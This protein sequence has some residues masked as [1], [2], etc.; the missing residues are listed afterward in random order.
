MADLILQVHFLHFQ[1]RQLILSKS[2]LPFLTPA[3][4]G[5]LFI[6]LSYFRLPYLLLSLFLSSDPVSCLSL[7]LLRLRVGTLSLEIPRT[8]AWASTGISRDWRFVAAASSSRSL[9]ISLARAEAFLCL[10][11][12]LAEGG[13]DGGGGSPWLRR[14]GGISKH[15]ELAKRAIQRLQVLISV[16]LRCGRI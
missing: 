14:L 4:F 12:G 3:T 11:D 6:K 5:L 8:R 7:P 9:L 13:V 10:L 1:C 15:H 16:Q 2:T